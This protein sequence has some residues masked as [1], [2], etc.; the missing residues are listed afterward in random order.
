MN[1]SQ[2]PSP[3]PSRSKIAAIVILCL[4]SSS[5]EP[6]IAKYA[7]LHGATPWQIL[8][9]KFIV[10]GVAVLLLLKGSRWPGV[11][12]VLRIFF[13]GMLLIATS[14]LILYSLKFLPASILITIITTTPAVVA[15]VNQMLGKERL[16]KTFWPGFLLC[17]TGILLTI[18]IH[19]ILT[20]EVS[21]SS[22][23][24]L[25]AFSSIVLSTVYR[26]RMD[27]IT[28]EFPPVIV[29]SY[30][31]IITGL[32]SCAF[33]PFILP[34]AKP[35]LSVG[36]I[37]GIAAVVAN[38]TFVE[39]IHLLG[40]TRMSMLGLLQRPIVIAFAALFLKEPLSILQITGIIMVLG[41]IQLARVEK[42]NRHGEASEGEEE[43]GENISS[44]RTA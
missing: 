38:V 13:M 41:G 26:T 18:E 25:C 42:R 33:I 4:V 27:D 1:S 44:K 24:L 12:N 29:S 19:R 5:I 21:F 15:L 9:I 3:K 32:I 6:I 11:R 40:S 31:F 22:I 36:A 39:A 10:G 30:M 20:G 34:V 8:V 28:A 35:S 2:D 23:G 14:A 37:V 7:Y 16:A 17:F 43:G